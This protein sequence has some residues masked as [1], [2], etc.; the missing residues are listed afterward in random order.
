MEAKPNIEP[1]N[2]QDILTKK[3]FF[4]QKNL[5][6][7]NTVD[8]LIMLIE[9]TRITKKQFAIRQFFQ[10][11]PNAQNILLNNK[12]RSF[13]YQNI[14][15]NYFLIKAIY[16]DKPPTTNWVVPW[17]QD[18]T[19]VTDQKNELE[20]FSKWRLKNGVNYV[21][22]PTEILENIITIRIH[23]DDCTKKNGA[24]QVIPSS[25]QNGI[26]KKLVIPQEKTVFCE[27][28]K[29]GILIM[30]PLLYH[31]SK[32]TINNLNRRVIHLEVANK[33]LPLPLTYRERINL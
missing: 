7:K 31:T 33:G 15:T 6:S 29:G 23:L 26:V 24:L 18:L 11:I 13:F 12:F 16:F 3:G 1:N 2:I 22:P 9:K 32:R 10:L 14:G 17:H 28:N 27:V 25:H 4:I 8:A 20:G 19:I 5:F 21:Q 30:K